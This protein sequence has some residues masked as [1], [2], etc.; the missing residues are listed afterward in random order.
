MVKKLTSKEAAFALN[1]YLRK[2]P[3][4][5][6]YQRYEAALKK[7]PELA[8]AEEE[9]KAMQKQL[10]ALKAKD[11]LDFSLEQ[12]YARLKKQFY[13]NPLVVNYMALKEEVNDLLVNVESLLNEGLNS[14]D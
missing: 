9:L 13:V 14:T 11:Q 5:Q 7:H 3:V 8:K 12:D 2:E 10:I 1:A 6:E 4:I